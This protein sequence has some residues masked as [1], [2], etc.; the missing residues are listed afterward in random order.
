MYAIPVYTKPKEY[1]A[2]TMFKYNPDTDEFI[3]IGTERDF[4]DDTEEEAEERYA[5]LKACIELANK[6]YE[7]AFGAYVPHDA[8][9]D[10]T[11]YDD[12]NNRK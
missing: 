6:E 9:A 10:H 3:P 11:T 5:K 12:H 1:P 4:P 2:D 8:H 7:E